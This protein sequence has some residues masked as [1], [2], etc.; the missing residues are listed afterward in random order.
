MHAIDR[1]SREAL[2]EARAD[3]SR[4]GLYWPTYGLVEQ[5]A[6]RMRR[7]K[8]EPRFRAFTG[9]GMIGVHLQ[10]GIPWKAIF[11]GQDIRIRIRQRPAHRDR[12]FSFPQAS[13]RC[14]RALVDRG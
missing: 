12:A 4:R 9:E 11:S 6:E 2:K 8:A 3:F 5:A 14:G 10:G 1:W 7:S 13:P